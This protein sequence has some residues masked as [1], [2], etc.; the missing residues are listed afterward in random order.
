MLLKKSWTDPSLEDKGVCFLR[1]LQLLSCHAA[2]PICKICARVSASGR[3]I[4]LQSN[5]EVHIVRSHVVTLKFS[6]VLGGTFLKTFFQLSCLAFICAI[7]CMCHQWPNRFQALTE[8]N[9]NGHHS[10][11]L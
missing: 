1:K 3:N 9:E 11:M 6:F 8:E 10:L 5:A 4:L 2:C 7:L